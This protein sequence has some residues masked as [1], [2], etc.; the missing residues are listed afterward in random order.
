MPLGP[1]PFGEDT[2]FANGNRGKL[3]ARRPMKKDDLVSSFF[4][5]G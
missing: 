3:N 2:H 5:V 1:W 4:M